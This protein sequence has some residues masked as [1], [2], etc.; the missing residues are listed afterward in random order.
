MKYFVFIILFLHLKLSSFGQLDAPL[1]VHNSCATA[2]KVCLEDVDIFCNFGVNDTF[3]TTGIDAQY[4]KFEI[5]TS[6]NV[7]LN[8]YGHTGN[9]TIYKLEQGFGLTTCE[10]VD[11]GL[12]DQISS[13]NLPATLNT[14]TS[15]FYLLRVKLT[16]CITSGENKQVHIT[17]TGN[18]FVNCNES[19][20]CK[21]CLG[22]FAPG[23]GQYLISGWVKGEPQNK[24]TSYLNPSLSVSFSGSSNS[25]TFYPSG[26]IID[27][28]QR[29][30]G[31][32]TI[33]SS[34]DNINIELK[35]QSGNCL[36]D[37]IRF[38]PNDGSMISYVYDPVTLKLVAQ[39]DERNFATLY[40]YDEEG[41]LIRTKK[42][43]EKGIMTVQENRNNTQ[44][45]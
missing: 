17:V 4:F 18:R 39:L 40:E 41:Q 24:N 36:F 5:A 33:P 13:G 25:F 32:V 10:L 3:C 14:L 2:A 38:I 37:D 22:S 26:P 8:T 45:P 30:E 35:C 6:G 20:E 23:P 11:L 43:T 28:W 12:V 31:V 16:N 9:Y 1:K 29:I 19:V 21:D 42:E 7:T 34:A 44:K 27:E 15:G